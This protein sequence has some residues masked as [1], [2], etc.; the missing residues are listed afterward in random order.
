MQQAAGRPFVR[1]C[2][3]G[4]VL[5]G[6]WQSKAFDDRHTCMCM[7]NHLVFFLFF[8]VFGSSFLPWLVGD[9][10]LSVVKAR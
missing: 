5:D 2:V 4:A 10:S 9:R 7:C 8:Y 6:P 1:T 3:P